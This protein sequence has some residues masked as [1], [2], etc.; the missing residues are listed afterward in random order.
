MADRSRRARLS[1]VLASFLPLSLVSAPCAGVG[2]RHEPPQA[3]HDVTFSTARA[4]QRLRLQTVMIDGAVVCEPE[5]EGNGH[6]PCDEVV[7]TKIAPGKHYLQILVTRPGET[8]RDAA[9]QRVTFEAEGSYQC[10]VRDVFVRTK[11]GAV[12]DTG[13]PEPKVACE[14][15]QAIASGPADPPGDSGEAT[16]KSRAKPSGRSDPAPVQRCPKRPPR[17]AAIA[18]FEEGRK[19]L[20]AA[21][22]VDEHISGDVFDSV[23]IKLRLA[24]QAGHIG[25]QSLLGTTVFGILFVQDTP[26][27]ADRESWIEAVMYLRTAALAGDSAALAFL[28]G[29]TSAMPPSKD[30]PPLNELPKDWLIEAW[31]RADAFVACSGSLPKGR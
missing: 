30:E 31:R 7:D 16:T 11:S 17:E 4:V 2:G 18:A 15:V 29:L 21:R 14:V 27:E 10:V 8:N 1:V 9:E 19:E 25:A 5:A 28:P 6:P 12:G 13:Y 3:G 23:V 22:R 24:A 26:R 20:D